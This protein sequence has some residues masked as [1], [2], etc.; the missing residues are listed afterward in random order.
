M[1]ETKNETYGDIAVSRG[2]TVGGDVSVMTYT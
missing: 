1:E 2:V